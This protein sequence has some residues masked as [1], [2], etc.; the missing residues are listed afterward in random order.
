MQTVYSSGL[1]LIDSAKGN[2]IEDG[3]HQRPNP[4]EADP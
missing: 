1:H 2:Q 4:R 3:N